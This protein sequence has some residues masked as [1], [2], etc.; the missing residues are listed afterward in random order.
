[1]R[2]VRGSPPHSRTPLRAEFST[3]LCSSS[4]VPQPQIQE[5][6]VTA[7]QHGDDLKL[8]E[9][10]ISHLNRWIQRIRLE[11][12]NVEKQDAQAKLDE[13]E[14]ALLQSKQELA[15]MLR[16]YPELALDEHKAGP[17][18]G[19]CRLLPA[20]G[21][22]G[23]QSSHPRTMANMTSNLD[24]HDPLLESPLILRGSA[25]T[26]PPMDMRFLV[27]PGFGGRNCGSAGVAAAR[28]SFRTF[29]QLFLDRHLKILVLVRKSWE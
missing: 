20:A 4:L 15:R 12:G 23:G 8:T 9:A 29:R 6:Q 27:P 5:L 18:R 7:D 19:D 13:L 10:E 3:V 14:A 21:G 2:T 17:G 24:A 16:E 22:R 28:T 11:I 1:M 25:E 26:P